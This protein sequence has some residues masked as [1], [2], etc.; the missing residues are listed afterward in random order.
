[1]SEYS[2]VCSQCPAVQREHHVCT[3]C[4]VR[5]TVF[6]PAFCDRQSCCSEQPFTSILSHLQG[7]AERFAFQGRNRRMQSQPSDRSQQSTLH[8]AS[9]CSHIHPPCHRAPAFPP[10]CQWNMPSHFEIFA[11]RIVR[12]QYCFVC[13][14]PMSE[15]EQLSILLIII[16][17]SFSLNQTFVSLA[18]LFC[19]I[20][21]LCRISF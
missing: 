3:V 21:D 15:L 12:E 17:V 7:V 13:I 10:I 20:I 2:R 9:S 8:P 14:S 1:M 18:Q 11:K 5:Q 19:L 4:P 6:F 16:S